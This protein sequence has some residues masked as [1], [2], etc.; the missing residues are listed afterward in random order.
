MLSFRTENLLYLI[1]K[2]LAYVLF[3]PSLFTD[4]SDA[5]GNHIIILRSEQKFKSL[6]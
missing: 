2:R 3:S 1:L 5:R 4:F 6:F